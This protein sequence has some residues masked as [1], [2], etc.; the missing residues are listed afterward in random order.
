MNGEW[1][2]LVGYAE[3]GTAFILAAAD[4]YGAIAQRLDAG[5]NCVIWPW[6]ETWT[7]E[8]RAMGVGLMRQNLADGRMAIAQLEAALRAKP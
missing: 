1:N 5:K 2:L 6:E 8:N 7:P 3:D 4:R